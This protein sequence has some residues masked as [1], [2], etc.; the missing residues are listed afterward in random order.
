[1]TRHIEFRE[2]PVT[3]AEV[4]VSD[5]QP[6][7]FAF[8]ELVPSWAGAT[9]PGGR[10]DVEARVGDG[11]G[12]SAWFTLA[13][14]STDAGTSTSVPDQVDG[15][16]FADEDT[17]IATSAADRWQ[18]RVTSI[19][20]AVASRIAA[21]VSAVTRGEPVPS[22]ESGPGLGLELAVPPYSQ[23]VHGA[24]YPQ[25][26]GGGGSWCSPTS[27]SMVLAFWGADLDPAAYAW[28]PPDHPDRHV[29][30]AVR[31]CFDNAVG[32]GN[33]SFNTAYAATRGMS[34]FVTRL[35]SVAEA[36]L[37][38]AAGVP[39]VASVRV[40]PNELVGAD[41]SSRGHLLIIGG[42]TGA[43]DIVCFDPAAADNA[44]VRR[45][46]PRDG[47][48]AAWSASGG[49]VYVIHPPGFPLPPPADPAEPNW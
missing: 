6:V 4:W 9:P 24:A 36:E 41:Y 30:H 20:A 29:V 45:V 14:W 39:L 26:D 15:Y 32:A 1:V 28:V 44:S 25:W 42:F 22:G 18:L 8:T 35:R 27:T 11:S 48:A 19:G 33:W 46:Y 37:F 12:W 13:R 40:D 23:R 21:M 47:F 43:G 10:L 7:A 31:G 16:G 38:I 34:A 3:P 5:P 17:V 49:I 2:L